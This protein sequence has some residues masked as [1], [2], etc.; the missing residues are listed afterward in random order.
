MSQMGM[1][2]PGRRRV[3]PRSLNV[4]SGLLLGAIVCLI[5]AI[6][7]VGMAAIQIGPGDGVMSALKIHPPDRPVDLGSQ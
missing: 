4:Y 5:A 2:M 7:L 6:V 3:A 1:Q